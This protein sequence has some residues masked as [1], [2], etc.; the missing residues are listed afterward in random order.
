MSFIKIE[1]ETIAHGSV[2]RASLWNILYEDVMSIEV[3]EDMT[4]LCYA[5]EQTL[6][7]ASSEPVDAVYKTSPDDNPHMKPKKEKEDELRVGGHAT[8]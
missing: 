3:S 8:N 2:L 6:V 4:I 1:K 5:D 7:V